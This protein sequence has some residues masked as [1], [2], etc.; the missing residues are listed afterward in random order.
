MKT[1]LNKLKQELIYLTILLVILIVLFKIL[2]HKETFTIILRTILTIFWLFLLPGYSIMF[3]W[4]NKLNFLER[5]IIGTVLGIA[6]IG[7]IGYNLGLIGITIIY[8]TIFL[9][10]ITIAIASFITW[11]KIKKEN[12]TDQ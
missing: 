11:K 3:Y 4:N 5:L 2:F 10:I 9:P 7:V 6:I 8:H 12:Q 1:T